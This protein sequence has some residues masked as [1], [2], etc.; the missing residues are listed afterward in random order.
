VKTAGPFHEII[1]A[2]SRGDIKRLRVRGRRTGLAAFA[3]DLFKAVHSARAEQQLRALGGESARGGGAES[4]GG[5]GDQ[6][7]FIGE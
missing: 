6:D 7:P 4:A 3:G 2:G 1:Y 5:S